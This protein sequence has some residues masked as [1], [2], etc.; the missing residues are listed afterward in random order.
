MLQQRHSVSC[1]VCDCI[2]AAAVGTTTPQAP[3]GSNLHAGLVR[4]NSQP[5][6]T[7]SNAMSR[8]GKPRINYAGKCTYNGFNILY[9]SSEQQQSY[10][11]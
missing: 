10:A 3:P 4:D 11:A 9:K 8:R 7:S 5:S 1:N 2:H 6:S